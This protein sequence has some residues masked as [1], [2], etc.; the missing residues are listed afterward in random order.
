MNF[1]F[2]AIMLTLS[3]GVSFSPRKTQGGFP[4]TFPVSMLKA[5][6][7]GDDL[8]YS[9]TA[10]TWAEQRWLG[11]TAQRNLKCVQ[12]RTRVRICQRDLVQGA[13]LRQIAP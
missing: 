3:I 5:F 4:Q 1:T 10:S 9:A 12:L 2:S 7:V 13:Y 6:R 8:P 11:G